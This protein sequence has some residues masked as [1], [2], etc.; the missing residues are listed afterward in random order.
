MMNIRDYRDYNFRNKRV[1][2]REDFNVPIHDKT[3][4]SDKRIIAALDTINYLSDQGAKII[5]VSHLGRPIEG[6]F[7]EKY[8]LKPVAARLS[9]LLNTH[10]PLVQLASINEEL[11]KYTLVLLENCRFNLGE[12]ANDDQLARQM[13]LLCD[14]FVMDAFGSAHRAH[15]STHGIAKFANESCAG[16]LLLA[17]LNALNHLTVSPEHPMTAIVGGSKVSTKFSVL[18][19]LLDQVELLIVGG[20]IANTFIAAAGFNVGKSLYEPEWMDKA[21]ELIALATKKSCSIPIPIDVV[22]AREFSAEAV[23]RVALVDDVSNNEMILDIG[24]Q[25]AKKF[26]S[27]MGDA[28]T[29]IWN[30]PVGVFEFE[31]FSKGTELI[32]KA[33]AASDA[34]SVAG[35]GDTLAAVDKYAI[36]REISYISTGGGAFLELLQGKILPAVS[37]L[38][39]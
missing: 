22:V 12:K 15:A 38:E 31:A 8:S 26:A 20:G 33:I 35:G 39:K 21:N 16:P 10:I 19:S 6:E 11:K 5:L 17:E 9:Q 27:M 28:K 36:E 30:G 13:A 32:A 3:I 34:Y 14:V 1:I 24:P 23:A 7:D 37:I 18:E 4:T 29:I 2:L 25:T